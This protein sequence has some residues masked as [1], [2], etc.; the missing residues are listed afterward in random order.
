MV[1]HEMVSK[2]AMRIEE[3]LIYDYHLSARD[4]GINL[5]IIQKGVDTIDF[6]VHARGTGQSDGVDYAEGF[7]AER[8]AQNPEQ[9]ADHIAYI[10]L[11]Y[12]ELGYG[13]IEDYKPPHVLEAERAAKRESNAPKR[14]F[15]DETYL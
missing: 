3:A 6:E 1:R 9:L 12:Q 5:K 7:Q 13:T 2:L 4:C 15:E 10:V 8:I 11:T 14:W